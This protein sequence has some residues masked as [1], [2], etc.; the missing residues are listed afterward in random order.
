MADLPDVAKLIL[1][2]GL[3]RAWRTALDESRKPHYP[4]KIAVH[5][6]KR[7]LNACAF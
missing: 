3:K 4:P 5:T 1:P 7:H 2:I 6:I